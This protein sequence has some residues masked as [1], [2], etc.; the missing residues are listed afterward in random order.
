MSFVGSLVA[1]ILGPGTLYFKSLASDLTFSGT[2]GKGARKALAGFLDFLGSFL[3]R[4]STQPEADIL[5][6]FRFTAQVDEDL[7]F[8]QEAHAFF[9]FTTDVDAVVK[10]T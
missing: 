8:A 1:N 7:V 3:I 6:V 4:P 5:S 10:F 9:E 2:V